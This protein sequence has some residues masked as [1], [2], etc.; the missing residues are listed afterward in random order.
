[1]GKGSNLHQKTFPINIFSLLQKSA[2]IG[3]ARRAQV[4]EIKIP[5]SIA[6]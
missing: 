5:A 1:M 2:I 6:S 3:D 4:M